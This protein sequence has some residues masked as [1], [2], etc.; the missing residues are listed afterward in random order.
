MTQRSKYIL[1]C[2]KWKLTTKCTPPNRRNTLKQKKITEKKHNSSFWGCTREKVELNEIWNEYIWFWGPQQWWEEIP[3]IAIV[4]CCHSDR[5]VNNENFQHQV[6]VFCD[7]MKFDVLVSHRE[8]AQDALFVPHV[9][10]WWTEKYAKYPI[11][12]L[13]IASLLLKSVWFK[14]S[15]YQRLTLHR[16]GNLKHDVLLL[17]FPK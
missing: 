17:R 3:L 7:F 15:K 5:T 13:Y 14:P 1:A 2:K 16:Q 4:I 9:V 11:A 12:Y 8:S 10:D 6:C